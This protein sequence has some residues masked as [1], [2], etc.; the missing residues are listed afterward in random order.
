M[1]HFSFSFLL[2]IR[3]TLFIIQL[4]LAEY[5]ESL[6]EIFSS[7][8]NLCVKYCVLSGILIVYCIQIM[9]FYLI[10]ESMTHQ[11]FTEVLVPTTQEDWLEHK[12]SDRKGWLST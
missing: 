3:S 5:H 2:C 11:R 10:R 6:F 1:L 4:V 12:I 8:S 7:D 9:V